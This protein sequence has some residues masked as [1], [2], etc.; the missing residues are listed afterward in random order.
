VSS[1]PGGAAQPFGGFFSSMST[2]GE[3]DGEGLGIPAAERLASQDRQTRA[4]TMGEFGISTLMFPSGAKKGNSVSI[5]SPRPWKPSGMQRRR[6]SSVPTDRNSTVKGK[7]PNDEIYATNIGRANAEVKIAEKRLGDDASARFSEN[8]YPCA[9]K[10]LRS[11]L[12]APCAGATREM[13]PQW[14][15]VMATPASWAGIGAN[16]EG[17]T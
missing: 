7:T 14:I 6:H 10:G 3:E 17:K 4:V 2:Q 9:L 5:G 13:V 12:N 8:T 1:L 16:G 15:K 11:T